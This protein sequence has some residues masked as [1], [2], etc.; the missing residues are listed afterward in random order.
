[1]V[2]RPQVMF[3]VHLTPPQL[4]LIKKIL[5]CV[6]KHNKVLDFF[7]SDS[8]RLKGESNYQIW[9]FT[10]IQIHERC[11]IWMY[12]VSVVSSG[13]I[14]GTKTKGRKLALDT[15]SKYVQDSLIWII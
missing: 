5:K 6:I 4:L 13:L 8:S 9:S 1:V 3:L 7:P 2:V 15:I 12:Y 11:R 14:I 10:M